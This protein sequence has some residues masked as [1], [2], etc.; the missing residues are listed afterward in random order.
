MPTLDQVKDSIYDW[1]DAATEDGQT[2]I[3]LNEDD[4]DYSGSKITLRILTDDTEANPSVTLDHENAQETIV[5]KAVLVLVINTYGEGAEALAKLL[6]ASLY[7][8]QRF[9]YDELWKYVGL[10]GSSAI[11]DLSSLESSEISDRHEFRVT[12][13]TELEHT[14]SADY[15]ETVGVTVIES[16]LGTVIDK[17][18]GENPHPI[19]EDC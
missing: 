1:V 18:M 6:R 2:I 15:A 17:T 12:L 16:D 10:G 11:Q 9:G 7:S 13:N 3:W 4:A 14:F 5:E 19:P 8:S